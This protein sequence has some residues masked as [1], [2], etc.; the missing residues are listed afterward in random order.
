MSSSISSNLIP[1]NRSTKDV[2]SKIVLLEIAKMFKIYERLIN[3]QTV[4]YMKIGQ[5][6]E[7][8]RVIY[9]GTLA[10]LICEDINP[11][12]CCFQIFWGGC[13]YV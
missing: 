1:Q 2:S 4:E 9:N 13:N 10:S 11:I 6:N 8:K 12:C 5:K 3:K 7:F